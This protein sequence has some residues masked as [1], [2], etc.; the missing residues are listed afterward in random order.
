MMDF[1]EARLDLLNQR[2]AAIQHV[3][4][5]EM[6]KVTDIHGREHKPAGSPDGGEFA[7]TG[8]GG[9]SS[10]GGG[11]GSSSSGSSDG[12]AQPGFTHFHDKNWENLTRNERDTRIG[13][14]FIYVNEKADPNNIQEG[15]RKWA[16]RKLSE[17]MEFATANNRSALEQSIGDWHNG[18]V[19]RRKKFTTVKPGVPGEPPKKTYA[20]QAAG[21]RSEAERI[22]AATATRQAQQREGA[23]FGD[24]GLSPGATAAGRE[25]AEREAELEEEA[26]FRE[27]FAGRTAREA[28]GGAE[29]GGLV[30][31]VGNLTGRIARTAY[32]A[33]SLARSVGGFVGEV[34]GGGWDF[35]QMGRHLTQMRNDLSDLTRELRGLGREGKVVGG[36][37][38]A[39]IQEARGALKTLQDQVK[40]ERERRKEE[41]QE[42]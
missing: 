9:G 24:E 11:S 28:V 14:A 30:S 35:I 36:A 13:D 3:M 22:Q 1:H 21:H 33:T 5:G 29:G 31:G 23:K 4:L 7:R 15:Q 12:S 2:V 27:D 19:E 32:V 20:E 6:S 37:A 38:W 18:M 41:K 34:G 17:W 26:A 8:G 42:G 25:A 40:A 16:E 10:S 39:Q